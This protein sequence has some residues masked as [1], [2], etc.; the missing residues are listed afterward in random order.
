MP[1]LCQMN[2][3]GGVS[4][5]GPGRRD[6]ECYVIE[7]TDRCMVPM[8]GCFGTSVGSLGG[9]GDAGHVVQCGRE[10]WAG[11]F[12]AF[13]GMRTDVAFASLRILFVGA[14]MFALFAAVLSILPG[15]HG[16]AAAKRVTGVRR[17]SDKVSL[18]TPVLGS[19]QNVWC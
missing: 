1:F 4:A 8:Q 6:L 16:A 5:I 3:F 12:N 9:E 7:V 2:P 10:M 14:V 11:R 18:A 17:C 15:L 19:T 13:C